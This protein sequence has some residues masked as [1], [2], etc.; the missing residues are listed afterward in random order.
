MTVILYILLGILL[1][2]ILGSMILASIDTI[3]KRNNELFK[4]YKACPSVIFKVL[5]IELWPV[6]TYMYFFGGRY[7]RIKS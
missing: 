6:V 2:A 3:V 4:W 5:V 7:G 1:N